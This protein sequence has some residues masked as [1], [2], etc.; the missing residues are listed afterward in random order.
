MK[1]SERLLL[2]DA[3]ALIYRAFYA[4]PDLMFNGQLLNAVYGFN[5]ILLTVLRNYEPDYVAI[6]F[7]HRDKTFRHKTFDG[8][9]AQRKKMP[10]ELQP[11]IKIVKETVDA[12]NI[13]RF[14]V[15]GYE[16][17]DLIGTIAKKEQ[18]VDIL[19][20][21]GDKDLLQLVTERIHVLIPARSKKKGD[22]EYDP[23]LVSESMG[24]TPEQVTDLKALMGDSSDNIPGVK[25]IG[26]K[27]ATSLIQAFSSIEELY[28]RLHS[29][30]KDELP[31]RLTPSVF[32]KLTEGKN[33]A[34]LSKELV[35]I[36]QGAPINFKLE[37]CR[38]NGYKK[39][40]AIDLYNRLGFR[41]LIQL[42]PADDFELGVQDALFG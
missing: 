26:K 40:E 4:F 22:M 2:F 16:A 39:Q 9:K 42:L 8:Y 25:G 3:H 30:E 13:P 18:S 23:L 36:Q 33:D 38:L 11:Q 12:L 21:T 15:T 28:K 35:T 7:D 24:V 10:E 19:I 14:E 1:N 20:V 6:A 32:K 17:D 41:S 31:M 34:L 5:R 27:T 37:D 29:V